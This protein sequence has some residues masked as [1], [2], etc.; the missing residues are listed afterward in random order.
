MTSTNGGKTCK[1][2]SPPLK[3][4]CQGH[5]LAYVRTGG[6]ENYRRERSRESKGGAVVR[7]LASTLMCPGF[8]SRRRRHM[9]VEFVVG[10]LFCTER[11]F[12]VF[13]SPYKPTLPNSNSIWNT[14]TFLNE[15]IRTRTM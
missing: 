2:P 14:W 15:F 9:W 6:R 5:V 3:T 12:S 13:P 7:A 8:K 1:A 11:F 10:S 4:T